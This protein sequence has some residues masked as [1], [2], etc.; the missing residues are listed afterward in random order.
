M[1][2]ALRTPS[3]GVQVAVADA[4][5]GLVSVLKTMPAQKQMLSDLFE[6]LMEQAVTGESYGD[7]RGAAY[8]VAALVKAR[9]QATLKAHDVI[10]RI[11][12]HATTGAINARQGGLFALETLSSRLGLLLEPYIISLMPVL[13]K[14]FSHGS[15]HVRQA[16]RGAA[17]SIFSKISAHGIKQV[18]TPILEGVS[19]DTQWKSRQEA[20]RLLGTMAHCAPRQLAQALPQIVPKLMECCADPHP[21]VKEAAKG[22]MSDIS[23]VV[24]NPEVAGMSEELLAALGDPAKKTGPALEALLSCEFMHAIDAPSL[25]LLV[26]I[27]GKG[28]RDRSAEIKRRACLITGNIT[29]MVNDAKLLIPYLPQILPGLRTNV[30]DPIPDVRTHAAACMGALAAGV[31][32]RELGD[33]VSWL[34]ESATGDMNAADV[35]FMTSDAAGEGAVERSGA[36]QAIAELCKTLGTERTE[37]IL[38]V[39][40]PARRSKRAGA[41]EGLLWLLSFL[42]LSIGDGFGDYIEET[43]PVVLEG[44]SDDVDNVREVAMRAGQIV[45]NSLGFSHS[46]LLVPSLTEGMFSEKWRIRQSSLLLLGDLLLLVGEA[47][48]A[49]VAIGMGDGIMVKGKMG[50]AKAGDDE[51]SESDEEVALS[52]NAST[53]TKL[54]AHM[55]KHW[56]E[57]SLAAIYILRTDVSL[58]VRQSAGNVWKQLVSN[59]PRLLTE[60]MDQLVSRLVTLLASPEPELA[61]IGGKALGETVKRLGDRVL[62]AVVPHLQRGLA[63]ENEGERRSACVGLSEVLSASAARQIKMYSSTLVPALIEALCDSDNAVRTLAAASLGTMLRTVGVGAIDQVLPSLLDSLGSAL[64]ATEESTSLAVAA[65]MAAGNKGS[66]ENIPGGATVRRAM[67]G[68]RTA[69][70]TRTRDMVD[71]LLPKLE[72]EEVLIAKGTCDALDQFKGTRPLSHLGCFALVAV[73]GAAQQQMGYNLHVMVPLLARSHVCA[74]LGVEGK[75]RAS[76]AAVQ[77]A[78]TAVCGAI[79]D[80]GV[81]NMI[82]ELGRYLEHEHPSKRELGCWLTSVFVVETDADFSEYIPILLRYL[83]GR[84]CDDNDAVLKATHMALLALGKAQ[85]H[86]DLMQH[87]DFMRSC[88]LSTISDARHRAGAIRHPNMVV[89]ASGHCIA[90]LFCLPKSLDPL[91]PIYTHALLK[92]SAIQKENAAL[93]MGDLIHATRDAVLKPYLIK[94]VGPL[95]RVMGERSASSVKGAIL[96]TLETLLVRGGVALKPFVPQ[97]QTT[98]LKAL[99][100]PTKQVRQ[101][102]AQCLSALMPLSPRVDAVLTEVS[103]ICAGAESAA[104]RASAVAAIAAVLARPEA[105]KKASQPVLAAVAMSLQGLVVSEEDATRVAACAASR[106]LAATL[107]ADDVTSFVADMSAHNDPEDTYRQM[108]GQ[109]LACG[110]AL[111]AAR[112]MFRDSLSGA[113]SDFL[114]L[115]TKGFAHAHPAATAAAARSIGLAVTLAL[116]PAS[117]IPED[118]IPGGTPDLAALLKVATVQLGKC[119]AHDTPEV[120]EG[121]LYAMKQLGR[122]VD[123]DQA[124]ALCKTAMPPVLALLR[125]GDPR[126]KDPCERAA[127][128]VLLGKGTNA[129]VETVDTSRLAAFIKQASSENQ[130]FIRDYS[131]RQLMRQLD[132]SDTEE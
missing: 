126:M 114:V 6:A 105:C 48:N 8:G 119:V 94:A 99:S 57:S 32:E 75:D 66:D 83:L 58:A 29:G 3:E 115:L 120:K 50:S 88:L 31:G 93:A 127:R 112:G 59:T 130:S 102:A 55:G 63:S 40:M 62:P 51:G 109:L 121:A 79:Q 16:A 34:L 52:A 20:V 2:D 13:I 98:F 70:A 68:L 14:S 73:A 64:E 11:R 125:T 44:L 87:L 101:L 128:H 116:G 123:N 39:L 132:D 25:G 35:G 91:L 26:P 18:M 90:P 49:E 37:Q 96:S 7:R 43:L 41:R 27:L 106:Q 100:D 28:L 53:V 71:Y 74:E 108:E 77:A 60:I 76:M 17:Q 103:S 1:V 22:A 56:A 118:V 42:P 30:M 24:K 86:E 107:P 80:N 33:T 10:P 45:V 15:D 131:K 36:A 46:Q 124:V 38:A 69:V 84:C 9:G 54:R 23:G 117:E 104:I 47:E 111:G 95:I 82:D 12:E 65:S 85:P 97:L 78:A 89:T 72:S 122:V 113:T 4:L 129:D 67:V 5:V 61:T 21:K 81:N 19:A 110:G 92:G